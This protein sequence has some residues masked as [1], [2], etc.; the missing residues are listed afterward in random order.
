[1]TLF[2][3]IILFLIYIFCFAFSV[4]FLIK[5]ANGHFGSLLLFL[6]ILVIAPILVISVLGIYVAD[7]INKRLFVS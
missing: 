3:I 1:M 5:T 6:F 4:E 2:E 7:V